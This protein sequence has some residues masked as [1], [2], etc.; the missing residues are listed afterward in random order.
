MQMSNSNPERQ[1]IWENRFKLFFFFSVLIVS[2]L[3]VF[4]IKDLLPSVVVAVA[5][6][7]LL[8]PVVSKVESTGAS[9]LLATSLVFS[10]FILF[11][12]LLLSLLT[13]FL[14]G[15]VSSLQGELP[16]YI[17]GSVSLIQRLQKDLRLL[18]GGAIDVDLGGNFRIW[19]EAQSK[20]LLSNLP[21]YLKSSA[22]V[23]ILSPFI[24]FFLLKD[25][26]MI[27]KRFL[28]L[29]PNSVY[30]LTLNLQYQINMQIAQYF[31]A[32][33][34]EAII[35]GAVVLIGLWIIQ[36]PYAAVLA[37]FAGVTNLIPYLGPV[38]GAIPGI[39]IALINQ[40][41]NLTL[42]LVIAVY[43]IA[44]LIDMLFIIPLVVAKIVDLHPVTVVLAVIVGAQLLGILGMLISIPICSAIKVTFI[45]VY[46]H[47]TNSG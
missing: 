18:S 22:S 34:L 42:F 19:M 45:S 40:E 39:A 36:F 27:S 30:E 46:Q 10:A 35:V 21:T 15:Q 43:A 9:R 4:W 28:A 31:R 17:D 3:A 38:V 44:Q 12:I 14:S 37:L 20:T 6:T 32:R 29:V 2:V 16:K 33:V 13:P 1:I 25:G 7:Y 23:I 8:S 5:F 24:A 47:V 41:P 26:F 11:I